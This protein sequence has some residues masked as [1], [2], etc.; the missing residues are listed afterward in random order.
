M[1]NSRPA[2]RLLRRAMRQSSRTSAR[3][4]ASLIMS[5]GSMLT[6]RRVAPVPLASG[7]GRWRRGCSARSSARPKRPDGENGCAEREDEVDRDADRWLDAQR[8]ELDHQ[9]A[10]VELA[11]GLGA[12]EELPQP[13]DGGLRVAVLAVVVALS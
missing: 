13:R 8:A 2:R 5:V 7:A 1:S 12:V 6:S 10:A 9:R 11:G 4:S 3:R